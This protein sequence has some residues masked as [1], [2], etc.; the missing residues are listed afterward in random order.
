M[1][2]LVIK[3]IYEFLGTFLLCFVVLTT[4]NYLAIGTA[5]AIGVFLFKGAFNPAVALAL[6]MNKEITTVEIVAFIVSQ[7]IGAIVAYHA[8]KRIFNKK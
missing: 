5:L 4:H 8:S 6:L 3:C 1:N 2:P 7:F